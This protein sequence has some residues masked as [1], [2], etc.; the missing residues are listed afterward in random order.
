MP[1]GET[2][3]VESC[4]VCGIKDARVLTTTTLA[5]GVSV[6]VCGSHELAHRTAATPARNVEELRALVMDRRRKDDRR[7]LCGDG[8]ALLLTESF[9]PKR[10]RAVARRIDD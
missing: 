2:V 4:V 7:S 9:A 5:D 8:L 1:G 6:A 3:E 10:R